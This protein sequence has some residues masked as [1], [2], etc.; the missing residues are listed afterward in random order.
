[1]TSFARAAVAPAGAAGAQP[2]FD[3]TPAELVTTIVTEA[4]VLRAPYRPAV[5]AAI[6]AREARR[7]G[8]PVGPDDVVAGPSASPSPGPS[9]TPVAPVRDA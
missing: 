5:A 9:A 2:A 6:A 3:V 1:M 8:T 4:G 7:P